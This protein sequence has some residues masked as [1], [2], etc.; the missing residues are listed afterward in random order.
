MP[1]KG[2]DNHKVRGA[3]RRRMYRT[4]N[5]PAV[6]SGWAWPGFTCHGYGVSVHLA[7]VV[8]FLGAVDAM[9][10]DRE[11]SAG[12]AAVAVDIL[13]PIATSA[14]IAGAGA[15][16]AGSL[17]RNVAGQPVANRTHAD[18]KNDVNK[19]GDIYVHMC[20]MCESDP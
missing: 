15:L 10:I 14:A 12:L 6:L 1:R 2:E 18:L 4:E 19:T 16:V 13:F 17:T 5:A 7:F 3:T 20:G 8:V 9:P 11:E